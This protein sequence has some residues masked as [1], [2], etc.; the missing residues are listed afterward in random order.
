MKLTTFSYRRCCP[1]INRSASIFVTLFS[2]LSDQPVEITSLVCF[3]YF[4][5]RLNLLTDLEYIS[6]ACKNLTGHASESFFKSPGL[7]YE[8][9]HPED[10]EAFQNYI[11]GA[12]ELTIIDETLTFSLIT[13]SMLTK[14]CEIS[15]KSVYDPIGKYLGQRGSIRD[16]TRL[17]ETLKQ[18]RQIS[19][20]KVWEEKA[21]NRFKQKAEQ[22]DREITSTLVQMSQKNEL[23]QHISKRLD[24][25]ELDSPQGKSTVKDLKSK[26]ER[27]IHS[28]SLWEEFKLHFEKNHPGFFDRLTSQYPRITSKDLKLC[29]YLRLQ[30]STKEIAGLLNITP[31]SAEISRVRLR[32]KLNLERRQDL[33]VFINRI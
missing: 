12:L 11:T 20:S 31:K 9:I 7:F 24:S 22:S 10:L 18:V 15:S 19:E 26:I 4:E 13:R 25:L 17:S 14:K 32:K 16:V 5:S 3:I 21:K 27:E 23:L 6:P 29:A 2:F 1:P 30:L 8:M 33:G 28:S